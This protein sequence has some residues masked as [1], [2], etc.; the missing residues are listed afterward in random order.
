MKCLELIKRLKYGLLALTDGY[1][2]YDN[3]VV[4]LRYD[5]I[6]KSKFDLIQENLFINKY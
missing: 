3:S 4:K 2:Y 1:M 5:L 6:L